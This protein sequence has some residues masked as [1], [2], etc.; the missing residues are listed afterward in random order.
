MKNL[1][2]SLG[3]CLLMG[4][5]AAQTTQEEFDY[6]TKG[7]KTQ[8]E[9]GLEMKKG[10]SIGH[11]ATH[12]VGQSH[13]QYRELYRDDEDYP[14]AWII[15]VYNEYSSYYLCLPHVHSDSEIW[16]QYF[17]QYSNLPEMHKLAV[18]W[19]LAKLAARNG[20]I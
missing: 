11:T 3:F 7:F 2:L 9:K 14:C 15:R 17:D 19:L 13:A 1:Y 8:L 18:G 16:N 4:C 6:C 12:Q 5:V 10:Y 20:S